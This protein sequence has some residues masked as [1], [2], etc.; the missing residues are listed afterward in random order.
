[1]HNMHRAGMARIFLNR[2]CCVLDALLVMWGGV[3]GGEGVDSTRLAPYSQVAG[4]APAATANPFTSIAKVSLDGSWPP[5]MAVTS[6][7]TPVPQQ[8]LLAVNV[9]RP[10]SSMSHVSRPRSP[11]QRGPGSTRSSRSKSGF[12]SLWGD[13]MLIPVLAQTRTQV[14]FG[15]ACMHSCGILFC[16]LSRWINSQTSALLLFLSIDGVLWRAS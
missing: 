16:G 3:R 6:A 9:S 7:P 8:Q 1:M 15:C 2:L 4:M 5:D 10:E 11:Y 12:D 14:F 13:P